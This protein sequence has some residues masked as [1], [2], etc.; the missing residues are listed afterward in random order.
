MD[1]DST[2]DDNVPPGVLAVDPAPV[3][4]RWRR[5]ALAVFVAIAVIAGVVGSIVHTDYVA[6]RPGSLNSTEE[7]IT[8]ENVT[9]YP[10]DGEILFT[11]VNVGR[12]RFWEWLYA[13]WFESDTDIVD[14]DLVFQGRS[15]DEKRADDL[16]RMEVSKS[17]AALVALTVLGYEV[18]DEDGA[19]IVEV[20][21][22]A[23]ADGVLERG[24]V[25]V[26][27]GGEPVASADDL[28]LALGRQ[29]PGD[30]VEL[31]VERDGSVTDLA[32]V[33]GDHPDR[34]GPFLG[35]QPD[36]RVIESDLPFSIDI[37]SGGVGGPSA[38]LA[39]T[40]AILDALT[41]GELTGGERVAVT[42]TIDLGGC[43]GPVGGVAQ[44]AVT[45]RRRGAEVFLVPASQADEAREA[46][47][48]L[49]IV[50]VAGL[51]DA[52]EALAD[53]GGNVDD[54]PSLPELDCAA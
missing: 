29:Q 25:V 48:E 21:E 26:A 14:A 40:L 16:E 50:P 3:R 46:A 24:D 1:E 38:G 41:E 37:D 33:L 6:L 2:A 53:L 23:P 39:F 52:L 27:V 13:E 4:R 12:L 8:A 18:F 34:D 28:Q 15:R 5:W 10:S 20:V 49:T 17:V 30:T 7:L 11:T 51:D 42:G 47:G 31:A 44:K 43:V 22:G 54:L 19:L 36:T 45:A 9:V 32:V 35:V